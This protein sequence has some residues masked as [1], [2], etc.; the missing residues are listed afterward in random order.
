MV[1]VEGGLCSNHC[2]AQDLTKEHRSRAE[3]KGILYCNA[4]GKVIS[5]TMTSYKSYYVTL[6][7][8]KLFNS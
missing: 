6:T 4:Q 2:N 5:A 1:K 7:A 8:S 3:D